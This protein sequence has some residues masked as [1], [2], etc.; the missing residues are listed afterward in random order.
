MILEVGLQTF[1]PGPGSNNFFRTTNLAITR[2]DFQRRGGFDTTFRT[3]EDR[4]FSCRWQSSG[5]YMVPVPRARVH[6]DTRMTVSCFLRR[7]FS[8]RELFRRGPVFCP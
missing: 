4:E 1:K 2:Q 3:S 6:P 5:G 7:H 8:N